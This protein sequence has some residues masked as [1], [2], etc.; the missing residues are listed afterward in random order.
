MK[1]SPR[2]NSYEPL[3]N[4]RAE[5][6]R[7]HRNIL[8]ICN[9]DDTRTPGATRTGMSLLLIS[10]SKFLGLPLLL[11]IVPRI[12]P[13]FRLV[14]STS[15]LTLLLPEMVANDPEFVEKNKG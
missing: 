8:E 10:V 7:E 13:P 9:V 6:L 5:D 3:T 11:R 12:Y 1:H 15:I 14:I 2:C 4:R